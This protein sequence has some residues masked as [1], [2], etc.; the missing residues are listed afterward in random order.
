MLFTLGR[1][2]GVSQGWFT[3]WFTVMG[4][5]GWFPGW[6]KAKEQY[7]STTRRNLGVRD[8]E[9]DGPLPVHAK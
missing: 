9:H 8:V 4:P 7:T 2:D 1:A 6:L 5:D 3:A